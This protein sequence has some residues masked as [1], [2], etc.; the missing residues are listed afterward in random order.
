MTRPTIDL[1]CD[2]GEGAPDDTALM[3]FITSAN[4]ACAGHAG[5][6][7]TMRAT[8]ALARHWGVAVGA[9]PGYYDRVHFGRRELTLSREEII[10]LIVRQVG[11][12]QAITAVGQH[13]ETVSDVPEDL[14]APVA[15]P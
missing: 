13:F 10:E 1:N 4:I 3:P 15:A 2:L 7:E 9:H 12:L 8:V 6:P 14:R 11:A 5:D